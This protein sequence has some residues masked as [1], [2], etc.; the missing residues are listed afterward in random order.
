MALNPPAPIFKPKTR[1]RLFSKYRPGLLIEMDACISQDVADPIVPAKCPKPSSDSNSPTVSEQLHLLTTRDDQLKLSSDQTPEQT[2]PLIQ[3]F[4]LANIK[5]FQYLHAVQQQVA[6]F[7][8]DL[9]IEKNERFNLC[10][11]IRQLE[12]ELTQLRRQVTEPSP[13]SLPTP[14]TVDPSC[15]AAFQDRCALNNAQLSKPS[16]TI[17]RKKSLEHFIQTPATRSATKPTKPINF[18]NTSFRFRNPSQT[19]GRRK[20]N[21][22]ELP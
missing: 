10:T 20:Y 9:N 22:Q 18:W 8:V 15:S 14:F 19:T 1:S 3:T 2:R 7:F 4:P 17:A 16:I 21:G 13:S 6:Q 12:E 5:Q 11:T